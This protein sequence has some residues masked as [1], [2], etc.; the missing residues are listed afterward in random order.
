MDKKLEVAAAAGK[1]T[2]VVDLLDR[3]LDAADQAWVVCEFTDCVHSVQG[4]CNIYMVHNVP[5]MRP[6]KPCPSYGPRT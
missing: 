5:K 3:N 2:E 4:R 6:S 1:K